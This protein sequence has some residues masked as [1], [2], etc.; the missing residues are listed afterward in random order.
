MEQPIIPSKTLYINNIN[1]KIKQDIVKKMLYMV[2][3]QYGKVTDVIAKKGLKLRGQAWV[4]FQDESAA[5]TARNGKQGFSFYG[6][7]LVS[8]VQFMECTTIIGWKQ[9]VSVLP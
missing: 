1:E 6:K 9:L 2:F 3:S 5:E 8:Q 4:V 7:P